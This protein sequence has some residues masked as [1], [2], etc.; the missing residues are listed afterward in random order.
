MTDIITV[1]PT[2]LKPK[3]YEREYIV[4]IDYSLQELLDFNHNNP[5]V[6]IFPFI[7][8]LSLLND[9]SYDYS[10][11]NN[12]NIMQPMYVGNFEDQ[13]N[14]INEIATCDIVDKWIPFQDKL[15]S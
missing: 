11:L 3:S 2:V 13:N 4:L 12:N 8:K 9:G 1:Y 15:N 14:I 7:T 6:L 5:K 10:V